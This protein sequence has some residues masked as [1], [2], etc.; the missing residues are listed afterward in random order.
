MQCLILSAKHAI[1]HGHSGRALKY[2]WKAVE[3]G[4]GDGKDTGLAEKAAAEICLSLGWVHISNV[5]KNEYLVRHPPK[6]RAFQSM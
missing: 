6:H 1:A 4:R 2:L 3:D 5:L